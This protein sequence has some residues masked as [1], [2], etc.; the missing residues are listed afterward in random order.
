MAR[1]PDKKVS[2]AK[3][4]YKK[5]MKLSDIAK[6]LEKPEGTIRRWKSSYNWDEK[7]SERSDKNSERSEKENERSVRARGAP[8]GN[9]NAAGSHPGAPLRNQNNFKHGAYADVYWDTLDQE[10]K[11]MIGGMDSDREEEYLLHQ[12]QLYTVRERR[13]MKQIRECSRQGASEKSKGFDIKSIKRAEGNG[14][15]K[16]GKFKE[17]STEMAPILETII[18]LEK[19][20][21]RVQKAK[22]RAIDSITRM[23][24]EQE[25]LKALYGEGD[26]SFENDGFLEALK[27]SAMEDWANEED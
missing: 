5:G 10:E 17:T 22:T 24:I 3:E 9:Q 11:D 12:I 13:L 27:G 23:H 20:L 21:T 18:T 6:K 26:E 19:E 16:I 2:Q 14:G 1:E 8:K 4:L 25:K 7:Q 15:L